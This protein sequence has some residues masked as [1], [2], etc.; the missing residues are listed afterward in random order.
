MSYPSIAE[1]IDERKINLARA[2]DQILT[3]ALWE[4]FRRDL[5]D[6]GR[7][8]NNLVQ[9]LATTAEKRILRIEDPNSTVGK[10]LIRLLGTDIARGICEHKL[11]AQF[12]LYNCCGVVAAY[13]HNDLGLSLRE[14]IELQNGVLASADC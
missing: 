11:G 5:P 6:G 3:N 7:Y 2:N 4:A 14:Q 9:D 12:G 1:I 8:L 10:Q 13:R